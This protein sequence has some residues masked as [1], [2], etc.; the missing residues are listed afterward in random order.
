MYRHSEAMQIMNTGQ[1]V[2]GR[3]GSTLLQN[4]R[5]DTNVTC[6]VE[7]FNGGS[8]MYNGIFTFLGAPA[9]GCE[10]DEEAD[11]LLEYGY[12]ESDLV[13]VDFEGRLS[14]VDAWISTAD[15]P[16]VVFTASFQNSLEV[17]K[18]DAIRVAGPALR[19]THE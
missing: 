15:G 12:P 18:D 5:Y 9:L 10:L 17:K 1:L 8:R 2:G 13:I 19:N 14:K 4:S 3:S 16:Q 11:F 7:D 6:K